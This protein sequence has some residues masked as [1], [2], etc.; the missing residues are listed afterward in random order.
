MQLFLAIAKL[1][2]FCILVLTV[3]PKSKIKVIIK[4]FSFVQILRRTKYCTVGFILPQLMNHIYGRQHP[5]E[6]LELVF[7]IW[8]ADLLLFQNF[9]VL[10]Y[11]VSQSP[12]KSY[13][14]RRDGGICIFIS[15]YLFIH[16]VNYVF[17]FKNH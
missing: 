13:Y 16:L 15:H 7:L 12:F 1:Q 6:S 3:Y 8:K 11:R 14:M 10:F 4:L 17:M 9:L 5:R 2:W